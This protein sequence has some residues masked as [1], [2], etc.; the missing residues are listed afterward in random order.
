[1]PV[2]PINPEFQVWSLSNELHPSD[3]VH[4]EE[5]L[6][7]KVWPFLQ[8]ARQCHD[9]DAQGVV[10]CTNIVFRIYSKVL[11]ERGRTMDN[12]HKKAVFTK[13]LALWKDFFELIDEANV[14]V[15]PNN[16]SLH[17]ILIVIASPNTLTATQKHNL[18]TN[19]VKMMKERHG[20]YPG[21]KELKK[22]NRMKRRH[23]EQVSST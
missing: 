13:C 12:Q 22:L 4:C 14:V 6:R 7:G 9:T 1:M 18:A 11:M 5:I 2:P 17:S 21:K 23:D 16:E 19:L 10:I 8:H 3:T 15:R 20:I